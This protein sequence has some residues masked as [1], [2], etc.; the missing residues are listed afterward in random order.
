MNFWV[1]V[2]AHTSAS[3]AKQRHS[4]LPPGPPLPITDERMSAWVRTCGRGRERR[5]LGARSIL[6]L[7]L[8]LS[9][10]AATGATVLASSRGWYRGHIHL[11]NGESARIH[12]RV[13]PGAGGYVDRVGS[14]KIP[15]HC[16]QGSMGVRI[17]P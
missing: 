8:A 12:L 17:H 7:A 9:A 6:L 4:R 11:G 14:D 16:D 1:C 10:L 15:L 2:R 13:K 5:S 3:R